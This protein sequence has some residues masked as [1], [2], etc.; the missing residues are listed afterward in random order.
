[1]KHGGRFCALRVTAY[2]RNG[3]FYDIDQGVEPDFF[4]SKT[5][6]FFDREKLAAYIDS[7]M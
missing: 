2:L 6:N 3:S 1:M 7:L 5:E 4:I